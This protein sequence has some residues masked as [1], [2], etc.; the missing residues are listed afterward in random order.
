MITSTFVDEHEVRQRNN[1][2]MRQGAMLHQA[3]SNAAAVTHLLRYADPPHC[4]TVI[5]CMV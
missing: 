1:A 2:Q 5:L 3:V 4:A